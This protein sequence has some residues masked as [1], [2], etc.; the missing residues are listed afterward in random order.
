MPTHDS[1]FGKL[2]IFEGRPLLGISFLRPGDDPP[3]VV[4]AGLAVLLNAE[5]DWAPPLVAVYGN[6]RL[7]MRRPPEQG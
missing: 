6:G 1:D 7:R 3:D 4:I 2:P 5:V